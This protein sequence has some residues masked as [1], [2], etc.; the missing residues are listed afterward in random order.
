MSG[1]TIPP[2]A[3]FMLIGENECLRMTLRKC[4]LSDCHWRKNRSKIAV[5]VEELSCSLSCPC[6]FDSKAIGGTRL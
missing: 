4:K 2:G 3:L 5:N 6:A 1:D